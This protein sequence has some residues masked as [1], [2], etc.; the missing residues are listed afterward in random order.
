MYIL[1]LLFFPR[2]IDMTM[3][4]FSMLAPDGR[5]LL[6]LGASG[7]GP[8][9]EYGRWWSVFSANFLHGSL[10]HIIFNM[11][12]FKQIAPLIIRE[13]GIYRMVT[14]YLIGGVIGYVVSIFAGI[15]FTI[16]ASASVCSLIG[17]ALYYGKRRGGV[18]GQ[19]VYS[20][21]GG[22]AITIFLFGFLVPGINNWGH[23]GGM[24]GGALLGYLLG[25]NE[26]KRETITHKSL[27]GISALATVASLLWAIAS[28]LFILLFA[29]Y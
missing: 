10:L 11:I 23:G 8:V 24:A 12:A 1:S 4:P 29:K 6:L 28:S 14:I 3:G 16:G 27:S 7:T 21:L 17:S 25:F 2:G 18:Y 15:H 26:Q 22:W 20:Q 13:Y 9:F 19:A 5:S